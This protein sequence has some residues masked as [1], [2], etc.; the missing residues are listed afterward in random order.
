MN[1]GR[2]TMQETSPD[3]DPSEKDQVE[4]HSRPQRMPASRARDQFK[5]CLR[6]ESLEDATEYDHS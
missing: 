6:D 2:A 4:P 3:D 1:E 5:E